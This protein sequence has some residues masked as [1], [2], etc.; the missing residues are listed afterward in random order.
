MF[1]TSKTIDIFHTQTIDVT[2]LEPM[3]ICMFLGVS[4]YDMGMGG[5]YTPCIECLGDD[6]LE[7]SIYT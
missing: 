1:L 6:M 3:Y 5:I 7:L 4:A 2:T